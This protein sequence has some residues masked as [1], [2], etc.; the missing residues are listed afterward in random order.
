MDE[1]RVLWIF[2]TS[3]SQKWWLL[4]QDDE[5][6]ALV[7]WQNCICHT[8]CVFQSSGSSLFTPRSVCTSFLHFCAQFK[9]ILHDGT[10]PLFQYGSSFRV[11]VVPQNRLS[12]TKKHFYKNHMTH[13]RL[14]IH[15]NEIACYSVLSIHGG[16][17]TTQSNPKETANKNL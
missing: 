17:T 3:F 4:L 11:F 8:F 7:G 2:S 16:S 15:D 12:F 5:Q 10:V 14:V 9:V 1:S 13:Y 6:N